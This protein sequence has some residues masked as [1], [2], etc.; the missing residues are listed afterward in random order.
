MGAIQKKQH[1]LHS[2]LLLQKCYQRHLDKKNHYIISLIKKY[3]KRH[4]DN[5]NANFFYSWVRSKNYDQR[6]IKENSSKL[7]NL[8]FLTQL[9]NVQLKWS[10]I[11]IFHNKC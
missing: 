5:C 7:A 1:Q 8:F 6:R 2:F 9:N 3:N 10:I 11:L 4:L